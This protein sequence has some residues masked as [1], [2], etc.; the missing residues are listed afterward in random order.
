MD[1]KDIQKYLMGGFLEFGHASE[2]YKIIPEKIFWVYAPLFKYVAENGIQ[3]TP[4]YFDQ[5]KKVWMKNV[6]D[7]MERADTSFITERTKYVEKL[8]N[9]YVQEEMKG[10]TPMELLDEVKETY[11]QLSYLKLEAKWWVSKIQNSME[12]L[13]EEAYESAEYGDQTIGY[14]MGIPTLDEF[15]SLRKGRN[16]MISAYA[17]TGKSSIS[18]FIANNCVRQGA[19]ILYFSLEIPE[20]DLRDKLFSSY[21][22]IPIWKFDKKSELVNA[23][24]WEY[25][26]KEIYLACECFKM[27]QIEDMVSYIK[28]DIVIIDYVQL[29]VWEG[30]GEYEQMND[31]ARRIR[32][33]TAQNNVATI[34]LSQVPND[35]VKYRKWGV[36]PSKW[37]G[38]LVATAN[39]VLVMQESDYNGKNVLHLHVAKN[40][41]WVKWKCIELIPEFSIAKFTDNWEVYPDTWKW[42]Y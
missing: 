26:N 13:A 3:K 2:Y 39:V 36:I 10:K 18:Y 4:D 38:E 35:S 15:V 17:N 19:K 11:I 5:C 7:A 28:P 22:G 31:V 14:Q 27:E 25:A 20:T 41:H 23:N 16:I 8:F 6:T 33:M 42:T 37:S 32:K 21:A 24:F 40:R 30:K 9:A 12:K 1:I 34:T 29:I